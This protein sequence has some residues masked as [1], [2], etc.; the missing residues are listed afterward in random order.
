M[1]GRQRR[2]LVYGEGPASADKAAVGFLATGRL[3]DKD[4][5]STD[6]TRN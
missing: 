6:V 4:V 5:H 2:A 1:R 3:P